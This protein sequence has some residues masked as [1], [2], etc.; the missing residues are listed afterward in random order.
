MAIRTLET[1][2]MSERQTRIV[3]QVRTSSFETI[4]EL[5]K[6]FNVSEMT[7]RRDADV[8]EAQGS[9]RRV[10]GALML[11]EQA[12]SISFEYSYR[13]TERL[14]EKQ[15][16]GRAAARLVNQ[17]SVVAVDAGTTAF[18]V[19]QH[20]PSE[21]C[22]TMITHSIPV[23]DALLER[24]NITAIGLGGEVSRATRAMVGSDAVYAAS[25]L[26]ADIFFLGAASADAR[27]IYA[28]S[29]IE[30]DIKRTLIKV[31]NKVVLVLDKAKFSTSAPVCI[32]SWSNI[33][34]IISDGNPPAELLNQFNTAGVELMV[35]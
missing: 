22:G 7:I 13:S 24:A 10:R 20:L 25:G 4:T 1:N 34:T 30:K 9:V 19:L 29:D 5:A 26:R 33:D 11:P 27:G 28:K 21:H 16:I 12:N 18:E 6:T 17:N 31:A 3:E 8:L 15:R 2:G 23:I 32:C 14:P 35:V